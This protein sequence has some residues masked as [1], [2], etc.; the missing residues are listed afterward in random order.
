VP[1][2]QSAEECLRS[3]LG[4]IPEPRVQVGEIR[5]ALG[6]TAQW[7]DSRLPDNFQARAQAHWFKEIMAQKARRPAKS[8]P[9]SLVRRDIKPA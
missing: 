2:R 6:S 3:P 1:T 4:D 8:N 7:V 9:L 5:P